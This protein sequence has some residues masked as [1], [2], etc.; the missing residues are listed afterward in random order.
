MISGSLSPDSAKEITIQS[1]KGRS[2]DADASP[3]VITLKPMATDLA[4]SHNLSRKQAEA[5]QYA[6]S[7]FEVA[8]AA[9]ILPARLSQTG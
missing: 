9:R 5:A 1:E 3:T 6:V 8:A 7:R 2:S 4:D